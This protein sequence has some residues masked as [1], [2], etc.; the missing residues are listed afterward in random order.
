FG[1]AYAQS[2]GSY[3]LSKRTKGPVTFPEMTDSKEPSLRLAFNS[4]IQKQI[5]S[6]FK[7]FGRDGVEITY[8][9]QNVGQRI[10][11]TLFTVSW[12]KS[13]MPHPND[14]LR[15]FNF[16]LEKAKELSLEDLLK[17]DGDYRKL[18]MEQIRSALEKQ[19]AKEG[20]D[21]L[22]RPPEDFTV[23]TLTETSIIFPFPVERVG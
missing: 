1:P 9:Q 2:A 15:S 17:K 7:T 23:F 8:S 13:P 6:F 20:L 19:L 11:S 14:A 22:F 21:G 4:A 10:I 3:H 5:D 16:D 18:L 12:Y